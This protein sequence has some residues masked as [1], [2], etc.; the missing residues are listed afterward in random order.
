[1]QKRKGVC[2]FKIQISEICWRTKGDFLKLLVRLIKDNRVSTV[3][4]IHPLVLL[5]LICAFAGY[6]L[7]NIVI[8][9]AQNT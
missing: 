1:M 8:Q 7:D 6:C 4:I 2:A 9:D 5:R 3:K